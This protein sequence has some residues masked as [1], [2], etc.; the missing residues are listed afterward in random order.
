VDKRA[1]STDP[2]VELRR[3]IQELKKN[4]EG[5][6]YGI[7]SKT[8]EDTLKKQ[9]RAGEKSFK[10]FT[11]YYSNMVQVLQEKS[12]TADEKASMLLDKGT[13]YSKAGIIFFLASIIFWQGLA[14]RKEFQVQFGYGMLSCSFLFAFIE[15]LSAW[16]LRQYRHFVD[17]STYLI[18]VKTML[19]KYM[20]SYLA[21]YEKKLSA[22]DKKAKL[23]TLLGILAREIDWPDVEIMK[24][25][26]VSF[27][28]EAMESITSV[29][30]ALKPTKKE[31]A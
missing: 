30:K 9:I 27:A 13:S 5:V 12:A 31:D 6:D 11:A 25:G 14:W 16:F 15:F 19:D 28:K 8:I 29:A 22:E 26:D 4:A 10:S 17:T 2:L 21:I 18:K 23:D 20:L 24:R 1:K 3:E 7:I